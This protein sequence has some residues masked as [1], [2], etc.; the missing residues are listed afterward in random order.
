MSTG[1]FNAGGNPAMDKHPFQGGVEILLVVSRYRHRD[2]LRP[3]GTLGSNA[4]FAFS[5][6]DYHL[7]SANENG[8]PN[9]HLGQVGTIVHSHSGQTQKTDAT[10]GFCHLELCK[11]L[12]KKPARFL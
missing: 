8:F 11:R 2:K 5:Q 7:Q 9:M 10:S 3:D 6:S 4:H 12:K 1:E